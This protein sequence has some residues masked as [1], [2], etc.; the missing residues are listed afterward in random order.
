MENILEV[1]NLKKT[2]GS[3]TAVNDISFTLKEGEILGF[4]GVNGAGKTTTIQML[5]GLLTPTEGSI[6]YFKKDLLVHKSDIMERVNFS[7]TYVSLPYILS[8]YECLTFIAQLYNIENR[9]KRVEKIIDMFHLGEL[10]HKQIHEL[11]AGQ[12]TKVNMAKAFINFPKILLL[13]EPTASLDVE[14]TDAVHTILLEEREKFNSSMILTSHNMAEVEK[15]CDRIIFIHNGKIIANDT[16]ENLA[17]TI[18]VSHVELHITEGVRLIGD[19]A[20]QHSIP[21]VKKGRN[22]IL[23]IHEKNIP[24]LLKG[25]VQHAI[26]YDEISIEKPTLEDYFLQV[27][28]KEKHK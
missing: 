20:N 1:K 5:L 8:V 7:S 6:H 17:K 25:L 28:E 26:N 10:R 16:P 24:N 9:K 13:D 3:F 19:Y 14:I 2:F 18:Q 27:V 4:L 23:D 22:I 11:S 21:F 12:Q 15:V